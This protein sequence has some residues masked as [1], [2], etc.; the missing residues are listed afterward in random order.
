M[1]IAVLSDIHS[2][3]IA[4]EQCVEYAVSRGISHFIFLGD[5][6]GE[7]AYP[8]RTMALL[9]LYHEKYDCVFIRGNK[10]DYWI[11]H[12]A[13]GEKGWKEYDSTTGALWYAYHGLTGQDIDFFESLPIVQKLKYEDLPMLTVCHGSPYSAREEM[14]PEAERTKEVLVSS[15]S[16]WIL[17]GHTHTQGRFSY[18]GKTLLNPGSVGLPLRAGGQSQFLLLR[19]EDK[20]WKEEFVSLDYDREAVL[21]QLTESGLTERTPYWCKITERLLRGKGKE[22]AHREVLRQAM[23]L[24][25]Q[26]TGECRWPNL[27]EKFW[28]MAMEKFP[29]N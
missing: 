21:R 29:Q 27:P 2:N 8:E 13:E 6:V 3:Y 17:C 14:W 16:E 15:Q 18:Q 11:R 7:M 12:R 9:R 24:C 26:E 22:I 4:L 20:I 23:E 25:R 19:G 10:E 5:Y 1:D 28:D